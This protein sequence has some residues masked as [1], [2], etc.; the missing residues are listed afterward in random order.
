[1][2]HGGGTVDSAITSTTAY[3]TAYL[4]AFASTEVPLSFVQGQAASCNAAVQPARC[5]ILQALFSNGTVQRSDF[6]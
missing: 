6:P 3:D 4:S 5:A 2:C 1:M